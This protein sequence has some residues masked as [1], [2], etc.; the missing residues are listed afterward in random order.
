MLKR[1]CMD[2]IKDDLIDNGLSGEEPQDRAA[3]R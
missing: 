2:S 3:W 1:M